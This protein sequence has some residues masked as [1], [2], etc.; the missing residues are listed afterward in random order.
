M[1]LINWWRGV[2]HYCTLP[3]LMIESEDSEDNEV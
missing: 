1:K 3:Q 2:L